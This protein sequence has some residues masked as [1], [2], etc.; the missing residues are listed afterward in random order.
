M[1]RAVDAIPRVGDVYR[2]DSQK[3]IIRLVVGNLVFTV[4]LM[5]L[6]TY[7]MSNFIDPSKEISQL[8]KL[9][10][11]LIEHDEEILYQIK[12]LGKHDE[13]IL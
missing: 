10:N 6:V 4:V 2:N 9:V 8:T 7:T 13:E 3:I 12:D 5:I 1:M 11:E